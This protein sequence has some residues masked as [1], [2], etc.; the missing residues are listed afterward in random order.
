MAQK[1][2]YL[3]VLLFSTS[4]L[5]SQ[6]IP[7]GS[8]G[9]DDYY[10]REQL[11]GRLDSTLSFS[12]RPLSQEVLKK[13]NIFDPTDDFDKGH[14]IL[15][16][17]AGKGKVQLLPLTWQ[18]QY[19]SNYPYGWN[20]GAMVP[21][22]GYQSYLSAGIYANY[23]FISL[24]LQPEWVYAQ[25]KHYLGFQP[26]DPAAWQRFYTLMG[27]RTDLPA[28]FGD[29]TY[30]KAFF[31][32]SSIRLNFH[33]ISIGLSTENI[34]WGPGRRNALLMTNTAP[35]FPH[36]TIN[37][38][39]P[40][41]TPIGSFEGQI[42]SGYTKASG[43]LPYEADSNYNRYYRGKDGM[44]KRYVQGAVLTYQPKWLPGLN[45]GVS[46]SVIVNKEDMGSGFK[47]YFPLFNSLSKSSTLDPE[48]GEVLAD[49][50]FDDEYFSI[51]GRWVIPEAN[52]EVYGEY[53]RTDA[54]WD[55]RDFVV[56]MEHT[57]AYV[58]GFRKLVDLHRVTGDLLQVGMEFTQMETPK[59]ASLRT[60]HPWYTHY[61][62]RNGY[63]HLGQ[64]L[65]AGVGP[66]SNVQSLE[67]SWIRGMKQL[68]L[69]I[70]RLVHNNDFYYQSDRIPLVWDFRDP[71]QNWVDLSVALK[72]V[73]NY[74]HFVFNGKLQVMKAFNYQYA[75]K[76][77]EDP[78][79]FW[80][81]QP[82]NRGNIQLQLGASYRF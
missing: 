20:D 43:F 45:L 38:T 8:N 12:I 54:P 15:W 22:A 56:Q 26:D 37:T 76:E 6:T 41:R 50:R 33:P 82:Q 28:Y 30:N 10:R 78:N 63:T 72:G 81:F 51:F 27:N 70:E 73:W 58:I 31:G 68:G 39:R 74:R 40:I 66:G 48:T 42:V 34:W 2:T 14:S 59:T 21:T 75:F 49:Q 18:N 47:D 25:N 32:Q 29:G 53:G 16:Q 62:V 60:S 3:F 61:R 36:I 44:S 64:V 24:Q 13:E 57:R 67:I 55:F 69:Q 71:R 1:F 35:G 77:N 11:L 17:D 79:L 65:G 52:A 9:L 80:E 7:V 23:K 46:R 4:F 5:Y 19:T